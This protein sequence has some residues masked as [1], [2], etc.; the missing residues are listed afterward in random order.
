MVQLPKAA[1]QHIKMFVTEIA[2]NLVDILFFVHQRKSFEEIGSTHLTGRDAPRMTLVHRVVNTSDNGDS[3][4]L[5]KFGM[6]G[7][8]FQALQT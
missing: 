2:S 7:Q 1:I 6:I 5:L 8:K 4:L 3:I